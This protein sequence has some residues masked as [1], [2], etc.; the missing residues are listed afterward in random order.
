MSYKLFLDDIRLP[1]DDDWVIVRN[2]AAATNYVMKNGYP[3]EVSFDHDLGDHEPT[4]YAF[5]KW[6]VER[7]LDF[8][9]MPANFKFTVHSANPVGAENIQRLLDNYLDYKRRKDA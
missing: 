6:L 8:G 5:A 2:F 9:D 3:S 4:G 1:V 7:D